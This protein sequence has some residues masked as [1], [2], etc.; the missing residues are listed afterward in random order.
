MERGAPNA[1]SVERGAWGAE[2]GSARA[3]RL[4]APAW[5]RC[6]LWRQAADKS[7]GHSRHPPGKKHGN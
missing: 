4:H 1:R 2:R 6:T 3:R 5:R 7:G